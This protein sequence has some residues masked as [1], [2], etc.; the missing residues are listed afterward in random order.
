MA[1]SGTINVSLSFLDSSSSTGV[2]AEK[3]VSLSSAHTYTTGVVA[4]VTGTVGTAV[5]AIDLS[6]LGYRNAAGELVTISEI[7]HAG[8]RSDNEAY[9]HFID[10]DV[11]LHSTDNYLAT[12]CIHNTDDTIQGFTTAATATYSLLM[13]GT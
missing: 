9:V 2:E 11:R 5:Q 12:S 7:D 3:K 10:V 4:I 1:V 13:V 8:F 6:S